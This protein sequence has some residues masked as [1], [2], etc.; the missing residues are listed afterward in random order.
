MQKTKKNNYTNNKS[1]SKSKIKSKSI[2]TVSN[3]KLSVGCHASIADGI[4]EAIKYVESIGGNALQ[5]FMGSKLQSSLKYKHKFKDQ[6]EINTIREYIAR[7]KIAFIIHS[8]Y[9]IN[10]CKLPYTSGRIKYAHDNILYDLKYGQM[11]GAKCVVLHIGSKNKELTLE[12]ALNNLVGNIN[13]II[14]KMPKGIM[15]SL[16]TAAGSGN[17]LGWNLEELSQI[18]NMI[19]KKNKGSRGFEFLGICI[20][21]A[22]IFVSGYD[23]STEKGIKD[24]LDKFDSLIG[25]KHISNF[26]IND[27][28]YKLGSKVDEHR[29]I[30]QGTI[31]N[32]ED[33]KKALKYIKNFCIKNKICMI[34]ETHSAGSSNSEGSHKGS[35]GYEYEINL[36]KNL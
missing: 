6:N 26:H 2:K 16:E 4:L 12:E 28:K 33:G 36:I 15:L 27:S 25:I 32:T 35:H 23:I 34:L 10:L 18:W 1:K 24:Y 21:T 13:H 3:N 29:G 9:T 20:D 5:I 14:S 22:H 11:L 30:G 7:N 8:I 17:Q 19:L 31:Y